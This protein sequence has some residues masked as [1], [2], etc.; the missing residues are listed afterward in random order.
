MTPKERD[1]RWEGENLESLCG[2]LLKDLRVFNREEHKAEYLSAKLEDMFSVSSKQARNAALDEAAEKVRDMDD[3]V[4][5]N[6][7]HYVLREDAAW[8]IEGM[9]E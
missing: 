1:V 6:G 9:K 8:A 4:S 5:Q 2:Q 7:V 3:L